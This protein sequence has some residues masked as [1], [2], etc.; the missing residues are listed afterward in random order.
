MPLCE[1]HCP[2]SSH[3][4]FVCTFV[5]L[6]PERALGLR[7]AIVFVPHQVRTLICTSLLQRPI[8]SCHHANFVFATMDLGSSPPLRC[9]LCKYTFTHIH[10]WCVC[11]CVVCVCERQATAKIS[12]PKLGPLFGNV[13]KV[14]WPSWG[15]AEY[16]C[17]GFFA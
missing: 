4:F 1:V 2:H 6:T 3:V 13:F 15:S 17:S 9:K 5:C 10:M 12:Q 8:L 16:P 14:I 11:M 7:R